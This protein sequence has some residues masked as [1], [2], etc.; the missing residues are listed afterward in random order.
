MNYSLSKGFSLIELMIAVV[1]VA[2]LAK[3]AYP[4]YKE[5]INSTKRTD[6]KGALDMLAGKMEEYHATKYTF[7]GLA[8]GGADTGTPLLVSPT[9]SPIDGSNTYYNLTITTA[10]DNSYLLT[11]TPVGDLASDGTLTRA[12][13]GQ[14]CW[15]KNNSATCTPM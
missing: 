5:N 4:S 14:K 9:K 8:T 7:K 13:T 6:A 11:A 3:M 2:I 1:I 15:Y 12:S 10:D